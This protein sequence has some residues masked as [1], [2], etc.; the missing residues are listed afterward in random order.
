MMK[1]WLTTASVAAGVAL[2]AGTLTGLSPAPSSATA[3]AR[4]SNHLESSA[5]TTLPNW[6]RP[7]KTFPALKA[8][9][10]PLT[11]SNS[12]LLAAG[13]PP[14]PVHASTAALATWANAV[15]HAKHLVTST[16]VCGIPNVRYGFFTSGNYAGHG[17]NTSGSWTWTAISWTQ[18][19]IS[20]DSRYS[21]FPNAPQAAFWTGIYQ[22]NNCCIVQAGTAVFAMTTPQ[23]RFWTEDYP[24]PPIYEGPVIPPGDTAYVYLQPIGNNTAY[25]FLE[26]QT[27]NQYQSFD[28][29]EPYDAWNNALFINERVRGYYLPNFGTVGFEGGN[30]GNNS[31]SDLLTTADDK[32]IMTSDCTPSGVLLSS[33]SSVGSSGN[34]TVTWDHSQPFNDSC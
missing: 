29:Y 1:R 16:P 33:T 6:C 11:A 7:I 19:R 4:T 21:N 15:S 20:A 13:L 22:D 23:Y 34:F 18:P 2:A 17:V 5:V 31:V 10:R 8:G 3:A 28:N 9:F 27:T 26:N 12:A 14:R 32:Y 25:Y 30:Y 24:L